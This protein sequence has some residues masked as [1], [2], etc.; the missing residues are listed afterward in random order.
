LWR[1][2]G[3]EVDT[4]TAVSRHV[5]GSLA[6]VVGSVAV[7]LVALEVGCRAAHAPVGTVQ[8]SRA[9]TRKSHNPRLRFELRPDSRVRAE[10]EYRVNAEGLRGPEVAV[11]KPEGVRRVAVLGDSIAFGYWVAEEDAFPRQLESMLNEVRGEGPRVE[12]LNF[13]VPGYNLDQEIETLRSRALRFAPDAVVV[14]FCLN[15]L[16]GVFSY[17]L[18]LVQDRALRRRSLLGRLREGLLSRSH[19]FAWVEYRLAEADARRRFARARNPISG[20]LYEQAVSDQKKSLLGK[21]RVLQALLASRGIAGV[22]VAFP[23]FGGKWERYP[24]RE[25]HRVVAEAAK[26]A[27]LRAV[28][29]LECYDAYAF[30]DARVDVVHPSPMGH[31]IAAHAIRD[32][33]CEEGTVCPGPVTSGPTC[34][35]Y[36]PRDFPTVRG[37]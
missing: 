33:L 21:L 1:P 7:T 24:H 34:R 30:R 3:G 2:E 20:P 37:Y 26:E 29:L 8:I 4:A 14:A 12:V 13:G 6:L 28:D 35:E 31:R 15:D 9:T 36:R 18:G 19:F 23:A 32:A 5:L 27:G 10:V 25:L 22:V 17:E 11:E 16:E